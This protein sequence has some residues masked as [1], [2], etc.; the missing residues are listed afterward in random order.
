MH[1]CWAWAVLLF[2]AAFLLSGCFS[3]SDT[4]PNDQARIVDVLSDMGLEVAIESASETM[5]GSSAVGTA[6]NP[7]AWGSFVTISYSTTKSTSEAEKSALPA[8]RRVVWEQYPHGLE[9]LTVVVYTQDKSHIYQYGRTELEAE[10]GTQDFRGEDSELPFSDRLIRLIATM[11]L[12]A[13]LLI[14]SAMLNRKIKRR[15]RKSRSA[16]VGPVPQPTTEFSPPPPAKLPSPVHRPVPAVA[17]KRPHVHRTPTTPPELP[18][19]I[20][21][22]ARKASEPSSPKTI[23][24]SFEETRVILIDS[25]GDLERRAPKRLRGKYVDNWLAER[26]GVP[27]EDIETARRARN[28][29]THHA[30]KITRETMHRAQEII[31]K[32]N[33]RLHQDS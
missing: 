5:G 22:I 18:R 16:P 21:P 29:A 33:E 28:S 19:T 24:R 27:V 32:V 17:P 15:W 3:N 30:D 25:W 23:W 13:G 26:S 31:D 1:R 14:W 10:L 4:Y 8:I 2:T 20:H 6:L 7:F 11:L 9:T 12:P